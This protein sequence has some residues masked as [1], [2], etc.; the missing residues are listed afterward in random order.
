MVSEGKFALALS[1]TRPQSRIKSLK[2]DPLFFGLLKTSGP[3]SCYLPGNFEQILRTRL[4]RI[5]IVIS[6]KEILKVRNLDFCRFFWAAARTKMLAAAVSFSELEISVNGRQIADL[7]IL[8]YPEKSRWINGLYREYYLELLGQENK[9]HLF[10]T[11]A[12]A[13]LYCM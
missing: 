13:F 5:N 7:L 2:S 12:I 11:D 8:K 1:A 3:V 6:K 4:D 10:F 9:L